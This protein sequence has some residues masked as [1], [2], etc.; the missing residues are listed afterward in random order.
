MKKNNRTTGASPTAGSESPAVLKCRFCGAECLIELKEMPCQNCR[1]D[2]Y[3]RF[4]PP[5][6]PRNYRE[7]LNSLSLKDRDIAAAFG[8]KDLG[9]FTSSTASRRVKAGV[10]F[11]FYA[12]L[13]NRG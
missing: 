3:F 9:A 12:A 5:G 11:V 8:Y 13:Y 6:A 10:E 1:A 4:I 7:I 2:S